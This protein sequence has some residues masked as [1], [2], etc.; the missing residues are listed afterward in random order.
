MSKKGQKL[1]ICLESKTK[2]LFGVW[3]L[4]IR[5]DKKRYTY[6]IPSEYIVRKFEK[7]LRQKRFG[8]AI[9]TLSIF[10]IGKEIYYES[11][12][13]EESSTSKSKEDN[14]DGLA[15]RA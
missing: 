6:L 10:N 1:T 3:E 15:E 7:L 13:I 8:K 2:D 4:V 14:K 12:R 11:K 5:S 9:H